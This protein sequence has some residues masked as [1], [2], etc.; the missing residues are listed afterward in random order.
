VS[1]GVA[2]VDLD[3]GLIAQQGLHA[4]R[5]L[6]PGQLG[7]RRQARAGQAQG[8]RG[9]ARGER[10]RPRDLVQRPRLH[11]RRRDRRDGARV[12]HEDVAHRE[13]VRAGAAH[14]PD[15]RCRAL[16]FGDGHEQ[17]A[18]LRLAVLELTRPSSM[19]WACA[20]SQEAWRQPVEK[21]W[22]PVTRY[23]PGTTTA[24]AL[25]TGELAT[26]LRGVS[27]QIARAAACGIR[28]EYVAKMAP[29]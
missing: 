22:R 3:H 16:A 21:P 2:H 9:I 10:Q 20:A 27:I 4:A 6:G 29:C 24:R 15:A 7:E 25:A 5:R 23:P 19:T 18:R 13:V 28:A 8:H 11:E 26:T 14:A 12:G 1:L 17:V